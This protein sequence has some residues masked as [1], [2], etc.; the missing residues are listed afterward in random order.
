MGD[1]P[2]LLFITQDCLIEDRAR[3]LEGSFRKNFSFEKIFGTDLWISSFL[4]SNIDILALDFENQVEDILGL[5]KLVWLIMSQR[6]NLRGFQ[7][8][9]NFRV[10]SSMELASRMGFLKLL[11]RVSSFCHN[12]RAYFSFYQGYQCPL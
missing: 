5:M 3:S 6:R 1:L 2:L 8:Q 12:S 11:S 10:V 7:V 9:Y 4:R